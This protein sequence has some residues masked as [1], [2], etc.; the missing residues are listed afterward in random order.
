MGTRVAEMTSDLNLEEFFQQARPGSRT[1]VSGIEEL[2]ALREMAR[3]GFRLFVVTENSRFLE[4][5]RRDF[6]ESHLSSQLMGGTVSGKSKLS[7]AKKFYELAVLCGEKIPECSIVAESLQLGGEVYWTAAEW[8]A[9]DDWQS[10]EPIGTWWKRAR[11]ERR[12]T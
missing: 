3:R 5:L 6:R 1:L 2:S 10:L 12:S 4:E 8:F 9:D 7:L 11:L